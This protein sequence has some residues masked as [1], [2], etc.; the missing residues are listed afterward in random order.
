MYR[1]I[2]IINGF[3]LR[4]NIVETAFHIFLYALHNVSA[5]CFC[6]SNKRVISDWAAGAIQHKKLGKFGM[7]IARK[8]R[9]PFSHASANVVLFVPCIVIGRIKAKPSN[10]GVDS[11]LEVWDA[12]VHVWPL[13]S[14]LIPE[15]RQA[16]QVFGTFIKTHT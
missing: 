16:L 10:P 14:R 13:M 8:A 12:Q 3:L 11:T 2:K 7:V 9:G 5:L 15:A 4:F 6:N 1:L